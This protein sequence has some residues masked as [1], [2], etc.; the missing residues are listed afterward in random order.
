MTPLQVQQ[1]FL[2]SILSDTAAYSH[3]DMIRGISTHEQES[4]VV[5]LDKFRHIIPVLTLCRLM[6]GDVRDK[7][8]MYGI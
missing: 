2:A 8:G 4:G 7:A 5:V 3:L 1:N 6:Q